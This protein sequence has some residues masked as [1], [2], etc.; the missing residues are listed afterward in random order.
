V[1]F[2]NTSVPVIVEEGVDGKTRVSWE[3]GG[4]PGDVQKFWD[5]VHAAGVASGSTLADLLDSRPEPRQGEPTAVALPTTINPLA[6]AAENLLRNNAY[7]V[8]IRP[9]TF[10]SGR[11]PI[12]RQLVMRK[13]VPPH[14]LGLVIVE[15]E[16]AVDSVV[17]SGTGTISS[18][19]YSET[20]TLE[21][22]VSTSDVASLSGVSE[23]V[24][25]RQ[26]RGKCQ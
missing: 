24:A 6:F 14:T 9:K 16:A 7:C 8:A 17:M 1:A 3:L 21:K 23:S 2:E 20:V 18:P 26:V 13:I 25:F 12:N 19:G 22:C 15:W 11:L 4:Y 10:G 5:D